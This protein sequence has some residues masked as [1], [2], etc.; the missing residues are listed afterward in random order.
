MDGGDLHFNMMHR[1]R[2][3]V[4]DEDRVRWYSACCLLGLEELHSLGFLHRD[5]KPA[6]MLLGK[7][8]YTK[9]R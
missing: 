8:G 2:R 9:V 5:I 7:D 3:K 6:N 4:F 1:T